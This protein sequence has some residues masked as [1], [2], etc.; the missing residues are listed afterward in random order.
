[1]SEQAKNPFTLLWRFAAS[2]TTDV[3]FAALFRDVPSDV[4]EFAAAQTEARKAVR[5]NTQL[6]IR[7]GALTR[8]PLT[9][10]QNG[11]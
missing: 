9:A 1:M 2:Q 11:C 7:G 8:I 4:R 10:R 3:N 6:C 5:R